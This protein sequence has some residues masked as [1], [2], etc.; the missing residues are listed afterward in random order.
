MRRHNL[1]F[2]EDMTTSDGIDLETAWP[3]LRA[4]LR[5]PANT[6]DLGLWGLAE[7]APSVARRPPTLVRLTPPM[8]P[9]FPDFPDAA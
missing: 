3:E 8:E 1:S 9:R 7:E 4:A 5:R 2:F 6:Q